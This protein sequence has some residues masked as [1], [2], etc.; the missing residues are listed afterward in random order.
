MRRVRTDHPSRLAFGG[1]LRMLRERRPRTINARDRIAALVRKHA[2][3]LTFSGST[4][5]RWEAGEVDKPNP[6]VLQAL[7]DLYRVQFAGLLAV[8]DA[9]RGDPALTADDGLRIL[10]A[11]HARGG[12]SDPVSSPEPAAEFSPEN[13]TDGDIANTLI[14]LAATITKLAAAVLG[15]QAAA[16]GTHQSVRN[17]SDRAHR[18][19]TARPITD[20]EN[21]A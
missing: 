21:G 19:P 20:P 1:V 9:N 11:R 2:P 15:R 13:V 17:G 10:E 12:Q 3:G 8:L 16:V 14:D 18:G 7:A 4:L 5:A 6:V